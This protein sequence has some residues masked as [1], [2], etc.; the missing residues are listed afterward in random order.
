MTPRLVRLPRTATR[1]NAFSHGLLLERVDPHATTAMDFFGVFLTPGTVI[2][3]IDLWPSV[4]YPAV[5]VFLET[6]QICFSGR[7]HHRN[8]LERILWIY[9]VRKREWRQVVHISAH[10]PE[11]WIPVI[12]PAAL[13]LVKPAVNPPEPD[14]HQA[15]RRIAGVIEQELLSMADNKQRVLLLQH[16]HDYL[17]LRTSDVGGSRK[18]YQIPLRPPSQDGIEDLLLPCRSDEVGWLVRDLPDGPERYLPTY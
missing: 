8:P 2:N 10:T 7:G 1:R 4:T 16:A 13:Q 18:L 14:I 12:V 17:S 11:E 5:P 6:C 9:K 15:A 3:E